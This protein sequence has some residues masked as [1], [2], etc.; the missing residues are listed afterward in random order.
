MKFPSEWSSVRLKDAITDMQPGFA[1]RPGEAGTTPQIRTHN[2]SP[3]GQIDLNGLKFINPSTVELEH[4]SLQPGDV[5]FNNT[6]SEEWVGKTA[7]FKEK[8]NY[9]F[10]NHMTRIRVD[11][12]LISPDFLAYY[13]H[14]LWRS[15]FSKQKAKRWVNQAGINQSALQEFIVPLPT[16][17]EQ[18]HIVN[19]LYQA[20]KL[21]RLRYEEFTQIKKLS[22]ALFVEKFGNPFEN[23]KGFKKNK[24][25]KVCEFIGGGTP[26]KARKDFWEG[27]IPWVSP[28]DMIL[29]Y[30]FDSE[31]HISEVGLT[32]S[33]TNII[34]SKSVLVVTRS[35]ILKH[36]FPC[37]INLVDVAINQD[38]KAL[39]PKNRINPFFL[40]FQLKTLTP[41]ILKNVRIGATVHNLETELLKQVQIILPPLDLQNEFESIINKVKNIEELIRQND[42]F[43]ENFNRNIVNSSF[44]GDLT[45]TWRGIDRRTLKHSTEKREAALGISKKKVAI[46]EHISEER[47]WLT[48]PNRHWLMDQLSDFQGFVYDALREWKGTLI[49]SED[50]EIFREQAFPVE[51]LEDAND[52]ILRALHQLAGLGLIAKIS[53]YNHEGDYVTAFRGLREE[54]LSQVSDRQYLAKG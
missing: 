3:Q 12:S 37:A 14:F 27:N 29:D 2:I 38:I 50:Q 31:D 17:L 15:G 33:A 36:T 52:Q 35:G 53:L 19:I 8:D 10:S 40:L 48:Q 18:Q 49:P 16:L 7:V 25:H 26:S 6:N 13:L 24:L 20:E 41:L 28:K 22:Q 9:V 23:P 32:D 34:P 51:H 46:K 45:E 5:I 54:E 47:P 1:Q 44:F 39:I 21:R 30:I 11:T 4:Y 43:R 42:L